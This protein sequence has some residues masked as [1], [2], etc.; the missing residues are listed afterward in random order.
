MIQPLDKSTSK[1]I[2][3]LQSTINEVLH[4]SLYKMSKTLL[5]IVYSK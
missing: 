4:D 5:K 2:T 3:H 1:G